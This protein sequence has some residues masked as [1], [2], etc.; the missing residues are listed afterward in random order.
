MFQYSE[1]EEENEY[2]EVTS[3][4]SEVHSERTGRTTLASHG[5]VRIHTQRSYEDEKQ[6]KM[7]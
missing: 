4:N 5:I 6:E 2:L 3:M 1:Q 7:A